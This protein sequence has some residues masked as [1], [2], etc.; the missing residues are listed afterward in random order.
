MRVK[1]YG[2]VV[3]DFFIGETVWAGCRWD[4]K[5]GMIL[6]RNEDGLYLVEWSE[7][8]RQSLVRGAK[9]ATQL[10]YEMEWLY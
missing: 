9:L 10:D 1:N 7:T 4:P 5:W 6:G 8:K 2:V 3:G